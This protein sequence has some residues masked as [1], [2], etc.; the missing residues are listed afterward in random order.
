MSWLSKGLKKAGKGLKKVGKAIGKGWEAIDDFALPAVGFALGG[1]A[2]AALGSAAARGIGDGKFNAKAT[3]GAGLKGYALGGLGQAAGMTGGQGFR[4][5][6]SSLKMVGANPM[7]AAKGA[8][9]HQLGL[10]GG[11]SAAG[12]AP[13]VN[14]LSVRS[15]TPGVSGTIANAASAGADRGVWGTIGQGLKKVG[16]FALDNPDLILG[17]AAMLQG[18]QQQQRANQ[19]QQ[20]ALDF[21]LNRDKELAPLRQ[22]GLDRLMNAQRPDLSAD[23]QSANPFARPLRRIG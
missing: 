10:G 16:G 11:G 7:A 12:G 6:G 18:N 9:Q 19:Y 14:P 2:G 8:V 21:A 13:T 23:F 22:R 15:M 17:G 20:Q 5:L 1:P 3:L 4:A